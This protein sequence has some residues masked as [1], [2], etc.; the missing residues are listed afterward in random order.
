MADSWLKLYRKAQNSAAFQDPITWKVWTAILMGANWKRGQL[1]NGQILEPGQM[2][3]NQ[4]EFSAI[5]R[6]SR[7]QL[8]TR[9]LYL[10][11]QENITTKA[12]NRGT[13]VTVCNWETYQGT[14]EDDQPADQPASNQQA[15]SKQPTSNQQATTEEEE[16]RRRKKKEEGKEGEEERASSADDAASDGADP[17]VEFNSE[18]RDWC[19][20]WNDLHEE[21]AVSSAV[22][23]MLPAE[24]VRAGVRRIGKS[25]E[26]RDVLADRDRLAVAIRGSQF[27]K[28]WLRLAK[29]L[30]G[31]NKTGEYIAQV[32]V[33]GGYDD[34]RRRKDVVSGRIHR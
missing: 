12:T 11:V 14:D 16:E 8:R 21:G 32:L 17:D 13:L 6:I 18:A 24:A 26:L 5:L 34:T 15:T 7:Q 31:K 3:I 10:K 2:L 4:Q 9:F 30:G 28:P 33:D 22:N 1:L 23:V 19:R 25:K 27:V 29:V 20:W